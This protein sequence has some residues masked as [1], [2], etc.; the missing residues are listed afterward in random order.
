VLVVDLFTVAFE[1]P[2]EIVAVGFGPAA[3]DVAVWSGV[4]LVEFGWMGKGG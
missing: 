1:V 4:A 3:V 2:A